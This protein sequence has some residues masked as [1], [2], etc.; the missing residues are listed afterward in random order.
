MYHLYKEKA[1]VHCLTH[2]HSDESKTTHKTGVKIQKK[3]VC[4]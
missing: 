1:M 2:I 3:A 4:M